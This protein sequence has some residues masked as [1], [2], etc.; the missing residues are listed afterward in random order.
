MRI[1]GMRCVSC[2]RRKANDRNDSYAPKD[3]QDDM[4][5]DAAYLSCAIERSNDGASSAAKAHQSEHDERSVGWR[6]SAPRD[7][8]VTK[9]QVIEHRKCQ[10]RCDEARAC[11]CQRSSQCRQEPNVNYPHF[12]ASCFAPCVP[13]GRIHL[14]RVV[15]NTAQHFAAWINRASPTL[16]RPARGWVK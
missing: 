11:A 3:T 6:R 4:L 8:A 10:E 1:R 16:D 2:C 9:N 15:C 12:S 13:N 5:F 14:V 7:G